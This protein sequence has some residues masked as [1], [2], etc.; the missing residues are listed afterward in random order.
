MV[1]ALVAA[2]VDASRLQAK[3]F[4]ETMPYGPK[5]DPINRRIDLVLVAD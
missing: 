3:G 2:G 4:G 5:G 1:E